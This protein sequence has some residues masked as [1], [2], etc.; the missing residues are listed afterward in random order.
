MTILAATSEFDGFTELPALSALIRYTDPAESGPNSRVGNAVLFPTRA[1]LGFTPTN[2]VW[3][4]A[5]VQPRTTSSA[6][7]GPSWILGLEDADGN[8]I[9]GLW[10]PTAGSQADET[11]WFRTHA[12]LEAA[13]PVFGAASIDMFV[14]IGDPDGVF[15]AYV[16]GILQ[17]V[18]EGVLKPG[19]SEL[20]ASVRVE[21]SS[22]RT[23]DFYNVPWAELIVADV[24]TLGF[25]LHTLP[26]VSDGTPA[27]F[28]GSVASISTT[29][30]SD[31]ADAMVAST[32]GQAH[33]FNLADAPALPADTTIVGVSFVAAAFTSGASPVQRFD[34]RADAA[35][36]GA[37][38]DI[39]DALGA[40]RFFWDVDPATGAAW[41]AAGIDGTQFGLE[42]LA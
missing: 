6:H 15:L 12:G 18:H 29:T 8:V 7:E 34:G 21:G 5:R 37:P 35:L 20:V 13:V 24:P 22:D 3:L 26:L 19:T 9:C 40:V 11:L 2:G 23:T 17:V 36:L 38:V 32:V 42:A 41:T 4:H 39:A 30:F 33:V 27:E 10:N 31:V 16:D 25:R 28:A 1:R 14:K